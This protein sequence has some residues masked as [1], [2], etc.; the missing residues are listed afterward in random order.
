[1]FAFGVPSAYAGI[2]FFVASVPWHEP[3]LPSPLFAPKTASVLYQFGVFPVL[4]PLKSPWQEIPA[5]V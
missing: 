1:L 3:Q 4:P 2:G 5:Q